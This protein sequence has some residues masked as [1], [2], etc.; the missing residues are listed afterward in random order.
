[1]FGTDGQF[2]PRDIEFRPGQAEYLGDDAKF[3]R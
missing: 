2:V 1:M 3:E